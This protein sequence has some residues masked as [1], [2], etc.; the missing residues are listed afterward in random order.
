MKK[1]ELEDEA[2]DE[3]IAMI[4]KKVAR[5]IRKKGFFN[6]RFLKRNYILEK[7]NEQ[8][9][10]TC[11]HFKKPGHIKSSCPLPKRAQDATRKKKKV[12]MSTWSDLDESTEK[13]SEVK[14]NLCLMANY[15]KII[16]YYSNSKC[17]DVDVQEALL[18]ELS[19]EASRINE[20]EK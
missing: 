1:R 3:E 4:T 16:D 6:M 20:L 7:E 13:N 18:E 5:I 2:D 8:K 19:A 12:I 17:K 15:N 9:E 11:Y 14:A 10:I